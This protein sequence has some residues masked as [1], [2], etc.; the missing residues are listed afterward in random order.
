MANTAEYNKAYY[1]THKAEAQAYYLKNKDVLQA[2]MKVYYDSHRAERKAY[3]DT[4]LSVTKIYNAQYSSARR[5][6]D[7]PLWNFQLAALQSDTCMAC[8]FDSPL[9]FDHIIPIANGG[10]SDVWNLQ[11]LCMP[12]NRAKGTDSTDYRH[13]LE[14]VA[15]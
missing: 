7:S 11:M 1:L 8:G 10:T 12:C 4:R 3:R 9:E 14:K 2:Q 13:T 6:A 5:G 15:A